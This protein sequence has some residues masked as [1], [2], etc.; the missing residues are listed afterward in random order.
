[1]MQ[2]NKTN[3]R[4][5]PALSIIIPVYNEPDNIKKTLASLKQYVEVTHEVIIV[6]DDKGDTTLPVL[7]RLK[8]GYQNI[9][10]VKNRIAKGPSGALRTGFFL[11][12]GSRILVVM[13]DLSDDMTQIPSLLKI[14][15]RHADIASPSRYTRHGRQLLKNPLKV[16][17]PKT[18][19]FM[20]KLLSGVSTSD[21]TNSYKL[22]SAAM[23]RQLKLKSTVSFS[24]TLEIVAKAH[25]LGF[26]IVEIPTVWTDRQIGKTNFKIGP[27]VFAYFPWF[28]LALLRNRFFQIPK[29]LLS[30]ILIDKHTRS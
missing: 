12:R 23:L 9:Q 7:H 25:V 22:Y 2:S 14:V 11:A 6:Y 4:L 19:G 27:S 20:L 30:N 21:P 15:P 16:W 18:A 28:C 13:A 29:S 3:I 5:R 10:V 1:M 17:L 26:T 24:V 8:K